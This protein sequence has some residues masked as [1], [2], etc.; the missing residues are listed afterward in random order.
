MKRLSAWLVVGS[1]VACTSTGGTETGNPASLEHFTASEC[2]NQGPGVAPQA[3]VLQS[4]IEGLQCVE[5]SRAGSGALTLRLANFPEPCGEQYG[6]AAKLAEDGTLELSVYKD[7]CEVLKCGSC[8]FDFEFQLSGVETS[9]PLALRTGSAV[10]AGRAVSWEEALTL[11]V[12]ERESGVVCRYLPRNTL[13][14]YASSRSACGTL[15]MPCGNCSNDGPETCAEGL[16]CTSVAAGDSRCLAS[17]ESDDDCGGATT[18]RD[19]V[20]QS[21]ADW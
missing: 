8:V 19:G 10:C 5:W 7:R 21:Q 12:D 16:S 3:L 17:C 14:Q 15:N 4:S 18:C 2:K 13:E 11:A 1:V 6:G 9:E 20:C